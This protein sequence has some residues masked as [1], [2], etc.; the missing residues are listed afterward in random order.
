[1]S[2]AR[3]G[4]M[5]P[6]DRRIDPSSHSVS[7]ADARRSDCPLIYVNRGFEFLTGYT[8]EECIGLN[9]R[10]LQGAATNPVAVAQMRDATMQGKSLL[11]DV[12]NYRKDGSEFWNRVSLKPVHSAKGELTQVIGIQSDITRMLELQKTLEQWA[13]DLG[14]MPPTTHT[15]VSIK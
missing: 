2:S 13:L 6:S 14:E 1:M 7:L 15:P 12:L 10:F 8:R 5:R 3:A 9:C 4:L 11:I